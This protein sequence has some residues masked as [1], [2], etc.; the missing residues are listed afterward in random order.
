MPS[1]LVLTELAVRSGA[2]FGATVHRGKALQIQVAHHQPGKSADI[3]GIVE[4]Y[5]LSFDIQ[6]LQENPA[7]TVRRTHALGSNVEPYYGPDTMHDC[8]HG[9][10]YHRKYGGID[11]CAQLSGV[12]LNAHE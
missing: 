1:L 2:C 5:S 4:E 6:P 10:D 12:N 8:N 9:D 7:A 3:N 11:S